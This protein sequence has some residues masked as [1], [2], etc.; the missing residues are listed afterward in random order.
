MSDG[1]AFTAHD[2]LIGLTIVGS[3]RI[4]SKLAEGGMG[5]VYIAVND[6]GKKKVVK[7]L[8]VEFS[9]HPTIRARFDREARAAA[10]L[11]GK[12]HIV[13]IDDVG[14]LP[15]GRQFMTMEHLH[16]R[17][18]DSHMRQHGRLTPHRAFYLFSQIARGLYELHIGGIIHRDLKPGNIFLVSTDDS[19]Y[20]KLIDLGIAHDSMSE[21]AA[22]F[23]TQTGTAMGT[24]GYMAPEQ[25]DNAGSVTASAD[26]YALAVVLWEMLCGPGMLPWGYHDP[27][28]LFLKQKTETPV[29][30]ANISIPEAWK[31]VL[32]SALSPHVAARPR[33]MYAFLAALASE[34]HADPGHGLPSGAA[35]MSMFC[36]PLMKHASL[37][38]GTVRAPDAPAIALMSWSPERATVVPDPSAASAPVPS[39]H[40]SPVTPSMPATVGQRPAHAAPAARVTTL[41]ASNGVSI[42]GEAQPRK[43]WTFALAL[44]ACFAVG[45]VVF[46]LVYSR[47]RHP[48][49][50]SAITPATEPAIDLNRPPSAAEWTAQPLDA[51]VAPTAVN[52][53]S[54]AAIH[55]AVV[56]T[57][58]APIAPTDVPTVSATS[59]V[60][61]HA[62]PAT[63]A[64]AHARRDTPP[65][66]TRPGAQQSGSGTFDPD[67]VEQ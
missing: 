67:A 10:R 1:E 31:P 43:S 44:A 56:V 58:T 17:T 13:E 53:P 45:G 39:S 20:V 24:P 62:H 27:R 5:A 21:S 38:D 16:G 60:V 37:D 46:G 8:L 54:D 49:E 63:P 14:S 55:D 61:A 18:L 3:Y 22:A 48:A 34:L 57:R 66:V 11:S 36:S 41:N 6:I 4:S 35:M 19:Y 64:P 50:D 42:P 51:A 25:V 26:L 30:P 65:A 7:F 33:S 59:H 52:A 23:H 9:R 40:P 29:F 2:P 47:T 15:D 28:V 12:P 32:V